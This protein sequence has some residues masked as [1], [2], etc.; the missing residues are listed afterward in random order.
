[1]LRDK[2][3]LRDNGDPVM[4]SVGVSTVFFDGLLT[5]ATLDLNLLTRQVIDMQLMVSKSLGN[6][7]SINLTGGYGFSSHSGSLQA[8]IR[9]NL[10]FAQVGMIGTGGTSQRFQGNGSISG[11]LGFDP[12]SGSFPVSNTP[13]VRH[14]GIVVIPFLDRNN[15]GRQDPGEPT[16]KHFGFEQVPGKTKEESDGTLRIMDLEPYKKVIIKTSSDNV[17]N[18]SWT[19][20]FTSF[21][22]VPPA[23]GYALVEIPIVVSGQIEGYINGDDGPLGG[24]RIKIRHNDPGDTSEAV[25]SLD[26]LSY[27]NGEY[28]YMGL[29]PGKYR[30]SI[31]PKQLSMLH[32]TCSPQ[33]LD[34]ELENKEEG[35]S[36]EKLNF[37]L[38][39]NNLPGPTSSPTKASN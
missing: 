7:A 27:S 29:A 33:Y 5:R 35:D 3:K 37:T 22:V 9:M 1:M 34:F 10:P 21:S 25:L 6:F 32:Y 30:A 4:G 2:F 28:Y 36:K 11:S 24:A 15:N 38:K 26:L 12:N 17:E 39:G 20:K 31:D 13:E 19:P 16:V 14:G 23:N 18:I 8:D